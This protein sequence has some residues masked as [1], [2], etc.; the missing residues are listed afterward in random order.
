MFKWPLLPG[1]RFI[2]KEHAALPHMLELMACLFVFQV[3]GGLMVGC[4]MWE[5]PPAFLNL[6]IYIYTR[7][8]PDPIMNGGY[9]LYIHGRK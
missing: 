8:A 5:E 6:G 7:W 9:N 4:G 3:G 1:S 2:S